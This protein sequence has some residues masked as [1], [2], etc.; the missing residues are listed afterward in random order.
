[1]LSGRTRTYKTA[2]APDVIDFGATAL[3]SR[4]AFLRDFYLRGLGR[5]SHIR[6]N[7]ESLP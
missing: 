5:V 1:M 4:A 7:L 3:T 6:N 2:G